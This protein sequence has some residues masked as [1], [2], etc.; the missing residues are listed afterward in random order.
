MQ[1]VFFKDSFCFHFCFLRF[2][3]NFNPFKLS[4]NRLSFSLCFRL[5]NFIKELHK[6]KFLNRL[7]SKIFIF[8][9]PYSIY[10][11]QNTILHE[12]IMA[13]SS[14]FKSWHLN[15]CQLLDLFISLSNCQVVTF[16][17]DFYIVFLLHSA[18]HYDHLI[19]KQ[20]WALIV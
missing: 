2:E 6:V 5:F 20:N 11:I 7:K 17:Y 8:N 3:T 9:L 16:I 14:I 19:S 1:R 18:S 12:Q 13:S 15:H 10:G 4:S